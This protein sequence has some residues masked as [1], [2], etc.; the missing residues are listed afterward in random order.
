[1]LDELSDSKE[2]KIQVFFLY[3]NIDNRNLLMNILE[4][5]VRRKYYQTYRLTA[6]LMSIAILGKARFINN[7]ME[8]SGST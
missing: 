7:Y 5:M 8:G 6:E 4:D 3:K 2:E 1:M